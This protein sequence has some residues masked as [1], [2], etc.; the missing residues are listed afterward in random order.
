VRRAR[1]VRSRRALVEAGLHLDWTAGISIGAIIAGNPPAE[2][3]ERLRQFSELVA[4]PGLLAYGSDFAAEP[5]LGPQNPHLSRAG[6][7][8][9]GQT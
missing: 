9:I 1:L 5:L 8:F 2:R 4:L 3:A 7:S 6:G